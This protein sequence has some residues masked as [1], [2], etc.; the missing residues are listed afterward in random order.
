MP[1][2]YFR[3][4]PN[5]QYL[6]RTKEKNSNIDYVTVKNFFKRVKIKDEI[7]QN[8]SFF[9]KYVVS[10]DDR[11]DNV[12]Y[13]VYKDSNLDWVVLLSNNIID[14]YSEWPLTESH[15]KEYILEK[16]YTEENL[17]KVHHYETLEI[18]DSEGTILIPSGLI[19]K[20]STIEWEEFILDENE[21]IQDAVGNII[22]N[23]N[24]LQPTIPNPDYLTLVPY[25][26]RFYDTGFESVITYTN[27]LKEVNNYEYEL[28]I[29]NK[30]REIYLIKP[31]YLN[32]I[33]NDIRDSMEYKKGSGQFIS[34]TLLRVDS[35]L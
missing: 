29:E 15:F 30:K 18:K 26:T 9:D 10:G 22:P 2:S 16:Y 6:N 8:I 33:F 1:K 31:K 13:K 21:F 34:R 7:F 27:I 23:P 17:Y 25:K 11:P 14:V 5:F 32:I 4:V 19:L 3:E 12:A 20:N 35:N 24:Y 28:S